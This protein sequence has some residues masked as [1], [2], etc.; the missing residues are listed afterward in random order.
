MK[1][2]TCETF[3]RY[4]VGWSWATSA[5]PALRY[6]SQAGYHTGELNMIFHFDHMAWITT[7]TAIRAASIIRTAIS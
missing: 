7:R 6:A 4:D 2:L 3:S 5:N 1:E